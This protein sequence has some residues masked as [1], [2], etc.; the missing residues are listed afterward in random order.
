MNSAQTKAAIAVLL[1]IAYAGLT[2][3]SLWK[4]NEAT[5]G[6]LITGFV[7]FARD[8]IAGYAEHNNGKQNE[9]KT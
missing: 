7:L 2:F 4:W 5:S 1:T 8:F 6:A 3:L 9:P